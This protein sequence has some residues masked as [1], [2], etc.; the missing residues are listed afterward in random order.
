MTRSKM[1]SAINKC[2]K[3][4]RRFDAR[5]CNYTDNDKFKFVTNADDHAQV[6]IGDEKTFRMVTH[7]ESCNILRV[8]KIGTLVKV[9]KNISQRSRK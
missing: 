2:N 9:R 4:V 3:C 6:W 5:V 7:W 1:S 8:Q